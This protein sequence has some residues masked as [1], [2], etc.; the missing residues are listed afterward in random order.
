MAS[1][2]SRIPKSVSALSRIRKNASFG[3]S[4]AGLNPIMSEFHFELVDVP[5]LLVHDFTEFCAELGM[6]P[7]LVK[8]LCSRFRTMFLEE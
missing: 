3:L 7:E 4:F 5:H 6:V 8:T 2:A 1:C